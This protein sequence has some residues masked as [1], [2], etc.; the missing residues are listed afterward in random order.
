MFNKLIKQEKTDLTH[1]TKNST[2]TRPAY[3]TSI[4]E[5][6]DK[7]LLKSLSSTEINILKLKHFFI[8]KKTKIKNIIKGIDKTLTDPTHWCNGEPLTPIAKL[9][10]DNREF[11]NF[12]TLYLDQEAD[13]SDGTIKDIILLKAMI[14]VCNFPDLLRI[15][16]NDYDEHFQD[17]FINI[18]T[19]SF[20][21][22]AA[23]ELPAGIIPEGVNHAFP[24]T[25]SA[26]DI[27]LTLDVIREIK[28]IE[29]QY[30]D[31]IKNQV[32]TQYYRQKEGTKE[33]T[34]AIFVYNTYEN[35]DLVQKYLPSISPK[36]R[37]AILNHTNQ[38][39]VIKLYREKMQSPEMDNFSNYIENKTHVRSNKPNIIYL[40]CSQ[41][42]NQR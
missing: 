15:D 42:G 33:E 28:R 23:P 16:V 5:N 25:K 37:E 6:K 31:N 24:E 3:S 4:D 8:S 7:V 41:S 19:N 14:D 36:I 34:S 9:I 10:A 17:R 26:R 27:L 39:P 35:P 30:L 18:F 2:L 40:S 1:Q 13:H 11:Q 21:Q 38:I 20:W 29:P 22:A 12:P 32:V